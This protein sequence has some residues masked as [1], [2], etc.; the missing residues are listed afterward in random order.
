MRIFW[1]KDLNNFFLFLPIISPWACHLPESNQ[2]HLIWCASLVIQ[3]FITDHKYSFSLLQLRCSTY[4]LKSL[5]VSQVM[6]WM[7][8]H[9]Q[10]VIASRMICSAFAELQEPV[11]TWFC[12]GLHCL[13]LQEHLSF[14]YPYRAFTGMISSFCCLWRSLLK[15]WWYSHWVQVIH[16]SLGFFTLLHFS[17]FFWL[18]LSGRKDYFPVAPVNPYWNCKAPVLP[19]DPWHLISETSALKQA[20]HPILKLALQQADENGFFEKRFCPWHLLC[21]STKQNPFQR[22]TRTKMLYYLQLFHL[23]N[24]QPCCVVRKVR[25]FT[26]FGGIYW[27]VF[28]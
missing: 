18:L 16:I 3:R 28:F 27:K 8:V 19:Y 22:P 26:N 17:L 12:S 7:W 10:P 23:E 11:F 25:N 2:A 13:I 24:V 4:W 1:F 21:L 15:A 5:W 6:N 20:F 14:Q 9:E